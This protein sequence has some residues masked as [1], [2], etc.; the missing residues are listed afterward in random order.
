MNVHTWGA[1]SNKDFFIICMKAAFLRHRQL[2]KSTID[3]VSFISSPSS[4]VNASR[5]LII[6]RLYDFNFPTKNPKILDLGANFGVAALFW[7]HRFPSAE[8][9]CFEPDSEII[10]IARKNISMN[11][12]SDVHFYNSCAWV[13]DGQLTF[14]SE[15]GEGG[16]ISTEGNIVVNCID[17]K[18]WLQGKHFDL[19]KMDIEGA[20]NILIPYIIDELY[21][22]DRFIFEW[23]SEIDEPQ[24]FGQLLTFLEKGN[25]RYH[26]QSEIMPNAPLRWVAKRFDNQ[27]CVFAKR[28]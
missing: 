1:L 15:W 23:H 27:I 18:K 21:K 20:E 28:D 7:K 9:H 8:I 6:R 5:D 11:G 13:E 2:V 12:M 3:G 22:C 17:L 10:E 25:Y 26:I 4:A 16:A 14:K 19:I 24:K